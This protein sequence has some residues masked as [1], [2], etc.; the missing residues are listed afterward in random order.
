MIAKSAGSHRRVQR[1]AA[2]VPNWPAPTKVRAY[3]TTRAGGVSKAPFDSLN[4]SYSSG[5][6][7]DCVSRN[8]ARVM[9]AFSIPEPPRWLTQVHGSRVVDADQAFHCPQ[10][11][12]STSDRPSQVL[13]VMTADCIPVLICDRLGRRVA[14]AHAGWR[15]LAA[16]VLEGAVAALESEPSQLLAWLGPGIGP[17]AFEVGPEVRDAFLVKD[18]ESARSFRQGQADRLMADLYQL[19]RRQLERAGVGAVFGGEYCTF[20]DPERFFSYRRQGKRSGRMGTFIW[21]EE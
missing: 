6:D 2:I 16:G 19:A 10:A 11:D 15:G 9:S 3:S 5:D 18:P 14:A 13:A 20:G 7:P 1:L 12:A 21:L 4:L 8:Q 17:E